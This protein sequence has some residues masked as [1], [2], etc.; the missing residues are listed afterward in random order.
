MTLIDI[1]DKRFN[2]C[3]LDEFLLVDSAFNFSRVTGN[4]NDQKM[5]ESIFLNRQHGTLLPSS[6]GLTTIAFLPANLP[7]V[8]TTTLPVLNLDEDTYTFCPWD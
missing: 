5:R 3:L 6:T 7:E 1:L 4:A 8:M 2:T